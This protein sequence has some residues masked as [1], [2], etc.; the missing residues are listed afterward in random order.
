M[1]A[2]ET[3]A[4]RLELLP[5]GVRARLESP[6]G[7]HLL[8]LSLLAALDHADAPDETVAVAPARVD[9][10][11]IELE[12]TS[13]V[14][15]RASVTIE[16]GDESLEVRTWV[17]G[18]G[19]LADVHLLGGRSLL[20]GSGTGF[21]PTGS[22]FRTLFSPNP[23]D[24]AKLVRSSGETAVIG[25]SGDGGLGR[26]HWFFTPAPLYLALTHAEVTDPAEPAEGGWLGVGLAAPV[27][28][29]DF[30]QLVYQA[31][32][33]AFNLVLEYEGHTH[34]DGRFDAPAVILTPAVRDPYVGLRAHRDDLA[35]R[36]AVPVPEPRTRPAWWSEPM[37]CGWGAQCRLATG[38]RRHAKDL[39]TQESYDTFLAV[40]ERHGL[41]PGTIVIDDKWQDSYGT[42]RA[43]TAKW[44]DLRGWIERRH[45]AGQHV[46]LWWKAWD[47][48]G[49]DP[50]LCIRRSDGTPVAVD[51]TNPAAREALAESIAH[52][53]G[54]DGIDADGL[55]VD[56]TARTPSGRALTAHGEGWG[57]ALL[58]E[59]LAVVYAAAKDAN[60]EALVITHIPHPGFADVTDMV[61]LN[62][63]LR[64]DDP[65]PMP[66][67]VP[68]MRFRAAVVHSAVPELLVDT[69]DWAV[70][71]KATWREYLELKPEL[72]VPSLYY[73]TEVDLDGELLEEDDYAAIR[74]T[75]ARWRE[76]VAR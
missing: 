68:Q 22:S 12:R 33:L 2:I 7:E 25:V 37:F 74:R 6:A 52:M 28:D 10:R 36:A 48:E 56:F 20:A 17:D 30:V 44:P 1:T 70:P 50:E 51:P 49:V 67:V 5:G 66:P 27:A 35:A 62:D 71:D 11:M 65:R 4:Y 8:T 23:G 15:E 26:G 19:D 69:D 73:A 59:L 18:R 13:T 72:G 9:G 60:P 24:P 3:S 34:V 64:I 38:T 63:M 21:Y 57:I 40:L 55:K 14:W 29:L 39:A 76:Q 54:R 41:A 43:D 75:W 53:L 32:D 42:N 45:E 58:H 61:R 47:T 31:G 46:L 16:C